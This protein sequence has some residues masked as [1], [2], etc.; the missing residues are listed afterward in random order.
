MKTFPGVSDLLNLLSYPSQLCG[1]FQLSL[2]SERSERMAAH[3]LMFMFK[4]L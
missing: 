3:C 2:L 4:C 1:I